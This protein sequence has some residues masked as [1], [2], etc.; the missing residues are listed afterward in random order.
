MCRRRFSARFARSPRSCPSWSVRDR[1]AAASSPIRMRSWAASKTCA[2]SG[3][4]PAGA[5]DG[6]KARMLLALCVANKMPRSQIADIVSR[7]DHS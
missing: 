5:L 2:Q 3:A 7:Y 4:M 1:C 6:A